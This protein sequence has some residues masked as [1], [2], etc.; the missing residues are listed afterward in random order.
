MI[1]HAIPE[2]R[3][4]TA[5]PVYVEDLQI[6]DRVLDGHGF[7]RTVWAICAYDDT[8][9]ELRPMYRIYWA[10]GDRSRCCPDPMECRGREVC[11]IITGGLDEEAAA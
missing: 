7:Y 1:A 10:T 9:H 6:D 3:E 11:M 2:G 5:R 4:I 8:P